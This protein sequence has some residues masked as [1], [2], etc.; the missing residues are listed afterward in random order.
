[1]LY[2]GQRVGTTAVNLSVK[3]EVAH[4]GGDQELSGHYRIC[5]IFHRLL[6]KS[7][8]SKIAVK[9]QICGKM[10]EGDKAP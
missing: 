4:C 2:N 5:L 9:K 6:H 1:V 10:T 7:T 3:D 8:I